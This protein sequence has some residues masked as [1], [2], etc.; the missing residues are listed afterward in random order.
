MHSFFEPNKDAKL[1]E[2]GL[3]HSLNHRLNNTKDIE[4]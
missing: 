4:G 1:G 2:H 3:Q